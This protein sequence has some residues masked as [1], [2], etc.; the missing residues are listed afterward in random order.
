MNFNNAYSQGDYR[1]ALSFALKMNV[2]NNWGAHALT[3]A[4]YGQLGERDAAAIRSIAA[5][6]SSPLSECLAG[7]SQ[8][9]PTLL[10]HG[11]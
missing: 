1:G 8:S 7:A 9:R 3:A 11:Y 2:T 4:A 10:L 5:G 6:I